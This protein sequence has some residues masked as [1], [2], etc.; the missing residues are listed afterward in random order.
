M[1]RDLVL[2]LVSF[3]VLDPVQAELSRTLSA[4][5]APQA[6][7]QDITSCATAG[8]PALAERAMAEPGWAVATV[9]S[10]WIGGAAPDRVLAEA[11]PGCA[12]AIRA[13]A[14]FLR[15]VGA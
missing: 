8:A 2:S 9:V 14:P 10:V 3:F 13:A 11:M 12:P 5:R 7:V 4:A 15:G 6:I 1:L